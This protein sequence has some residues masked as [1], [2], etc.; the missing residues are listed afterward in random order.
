MTKRPAYLKFT[1]RRPKAC[2]CGMRITEKQTKCERCA[3]IEQ[4]RAAQSQEISA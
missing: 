2:L 3:A 4:R 1:V